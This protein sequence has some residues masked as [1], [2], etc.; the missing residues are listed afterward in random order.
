M[1]LIKKI[2]NFGKINVIYNLESEIITEEIDIDFIKKRLNPENKNIEFHLIYK[3]NENNDS[4]KIFHEKCDGKQNVIVFIETNE[5]IKF[6]GYTSIGF[7]SKSCDTKDN[8]A[9]IFSIDKKKI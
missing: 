9:F 5:G 1:K 2:Q 4:P 6:G 8:K 3:C 7:N